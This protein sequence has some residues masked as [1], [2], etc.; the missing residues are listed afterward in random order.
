MPS[1]SVLIIPLGLKEAR[2][3][4]HSHRIEA[5]VWH[6]EFSLLCATCE[7]S[8]GVAELTCHL[9]HGLSVALAL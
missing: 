1:H 8:I 3:F 9:R 4:A 6:Q 7:A 5:Q 2:Q